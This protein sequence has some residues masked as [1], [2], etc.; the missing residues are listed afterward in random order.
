M[1]KS[2][3]H[4]SLVRTGNLIGL[5]SDNPANFYLLKN[6]LDLAYWQLDYHPLGK[7]RN[8]FTNRRVSGLNGRI[9][10]GDA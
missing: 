4:T 3:L 1:E 7:L 8:G 5:A 9:L 6:R 10:Q 2:H